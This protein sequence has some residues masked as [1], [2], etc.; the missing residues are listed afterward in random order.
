MRPPKILLIGFDLRALITWDHMEPDLSTL[1]LHAALQALRRGDFSSLELTQACLRQIERLDQSINAFITLTPE[2]AVQAAM[3]ADALHSI[4]PSNLNDLALLGIPIALKDLFETEGIRT[5]GGSRFFADL[6]PAEDAEAVRKLKLAGA[7]LLG[8]T[9]THEFALGVTGVNPH[10]GA[11]KNPWDTSRIT[12]GSS[13]GSA[14]AV[15]VGMCLAALGTDT[16]GSIRIPASLCGVVGVKPTFGRVSTRGVV[17]LS[18]NLDHVGIL[19]RT[20]K[21]AA[22]MLHV[23]AGFDPHDSASVDA[24]VADYLVKLDNGVGSLRIALGVGEYIDASDPDVLAALDTSARVYKDLGAQVEKVDLSWISELA[25][26][27]SRMTQADAA[28]FHRERLGTH[29]DWFG[30]DIRQRLEAGA[31]LSSSEYS[32]A[33]RV[34]SEGRRRFEMF[35][36]KYDLLLLP[37]TPIPAPEIAGTGAIEAARQLTRFTSPFNLTGLPALSIP[38][39]LSNNGLPL[40]LQ[41]VTRHWGEAQ[42]LQAGHAF[43]HATEWHSHLPEMVKKQM[44]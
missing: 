8:K 14:A 27:N 37:S 1:T 28:A 7:V 19:A 25:L 10:Y 35:F 12:G 3:Q 29:P 44:G 30:D 31:A 33:R 6:I 11:V 9:N 17:P 4:H 23:L 13:S 22:I 40:G 24:P 15:A 38:C 5:T 34:Q 20:I 2:L 32:L 42:L 16:G 39:G 43:E 18:W 21:D 26:A 41:I 36:T